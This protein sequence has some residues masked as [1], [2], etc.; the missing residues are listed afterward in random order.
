MARDCL[1]SYLAV[2][3]EASEGGDVLDGQIGLRGSRSDVSLLTDA[4]DLLVHLKIDRQK[5][6]S[7]R[8]TC[9]IAC[10]TAGAGVC[11]GLEKTEIH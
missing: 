6:I 2:V 1:T 9:K 3:G 4:V 7:Y 8:E 5:G 11:G 10:S